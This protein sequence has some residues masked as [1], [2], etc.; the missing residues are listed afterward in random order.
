MLEYFDQTTQAGFYLFT[1]VFVAL[2]MMVIAQKTNT[3]NGWLA[4]IP[5]ANIYLMT[6][7]ADVDWWWVLVCLIPC[8]NIIGFIYLFMK[9]SAARGRPELMG[10][11]MLVPCVNFLYLAYLAFAD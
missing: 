11:L 8:V 2:C 9:I 3:P 7:I 1:Y 10:L 4:W 5:I 6:Q